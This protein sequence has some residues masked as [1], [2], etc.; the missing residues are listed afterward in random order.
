MAAVNELPFGKYYGGVD[1]TPLFVMLAAEYARRTGDLAFIDS[2]WRALLAPPRGSRT[3]R[4]DTAASSATLAARPPGLNNQGW[5]DGHD[6]V[7]HADGSSPVGPIALVE[8]QGYAYAAF[9]GM[10]DLARERGDEAGTARWNDAAVDLAAR[11]E[12]KF[13]RDELQFYALALDGA[14]RPLPRARVGGTTGRGGVHL[15]AQGLRRPMPDR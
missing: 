10:A 1:T 12:S 8:V 4:D 2:I 14:W 5:K 11:V 6:S 13:W 15:L 7:F 3:T 9:C